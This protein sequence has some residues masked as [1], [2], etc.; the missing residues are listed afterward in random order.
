MISHNHRQPNVQQ[1]RM[2]KLVVGAALAMSVATAGVAGAD[3]GITVFQPQQVYVQDFGPAVTVVVTSANPGPQSCP[4]AGSAPDPDSVC[5]AMHIR[6]AFQSDLG[7]FVPLTVGN[8]PDPVTKRATTGVGCL[9]D[10]VWRGEFFQY[11]VSSEPGVMR[12]D[13]RWGNTKYTENCA[14]DVAPPV[15]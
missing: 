11:I 15:P 9:P 12:P 6:I 13:L 4:G 2:K 10:T 8:S 14:G 5:K 7:D 1:T 3:T